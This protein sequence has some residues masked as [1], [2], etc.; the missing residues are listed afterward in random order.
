[1]IQPDID[2]LCWAI[3]ALEGQFALFLA[4]CNSSTL[5]QRTIEQIATNISGSHILQVPNTT[6]NL[7]GWLRQETLQP[8][9]NALMLDFEEMQDIPN[10]VI[11]MNQQRNDYTQFQFPIVLWGND[12]FATAIARFAPDFV[13]W[14]VSANFNEETP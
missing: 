2:S 4:R 1:M 10:L 14:A 12:E 9:V 8:P 6:L 3:K 11:A 5:R 13:S 7:L